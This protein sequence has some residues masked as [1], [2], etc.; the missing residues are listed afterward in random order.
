MSR[1]QPSEWTR[2][3]S[4]RY[5]R[6][7]CRLMNAN[8]LPIDAI[9]A[10]MAR[11]LIATSPGSDDQRRHIFGALNRFMDWC[12]KQEL[13]KVNPCAN[14]DRRDRPGPGKSRDH[15]PSILTLKS[16]LAAVDAEDELARSLTGFMLFMPVRRSEASGLLWSEVDFDQGRIRI[17]A[18]RTKN[19]HAHE[20]PL[21]PPAR[22]ILEARKL[23]AA[24]NLVFAT[25][26]G[27]P[28]TN[29]DRLLT[30]IRKAIG[31][32]GKDR[33]NQFSLHDIRRAFVSHLA[34]Q[35]DIDALD[36][37]LGHVRGG[38]AGVYQR[39]QRWPERERA[40]NAWAALITGIEPNSA[41]I[42]P[43]SNVRPFVRHAHV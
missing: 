29:W 17:Q 38:V 9:D 2:K 27:G 22:A 14:I 32:D 3:Q 31:E 5:A 1:R 18:S 26:G 4:I 28:Y 35:F 16:V 6:L 21:S 8:A 15:V 23:V 40:L 30:R 33:D 41:E 42:E 25:S 13:I 37:C 10:R 19:G 11:M 34:G 20:L 43:D 24:G 12:C 7:A 36:Q 39:S